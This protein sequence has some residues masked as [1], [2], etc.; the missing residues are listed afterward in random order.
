MSFL[1]YKKV[2][3]FCV[4]YY[5]LEHA[6]FFNVKFAEVCFVKL[7]NLLSK[8]SQEQGFIGLNTFQ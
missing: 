3:T 2:N 8:F 1:V 4:P 6:F 7:K 5:E